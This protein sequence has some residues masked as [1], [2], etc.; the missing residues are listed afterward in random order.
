[1]A[2]RTLTPMN[3]P[4]TH[5]GV[6]LP[7]RAE[8]HD[9]P[10]RLATLLAAASLATLLTQLTVFASGTPVAAATAPRTP[11][12]A[13]ES[14]A[15]T[16]S[17]GETVATA[18]A[19]SRV[20]SVAAPTCSRAYE[21]GGPSRLLG[22]V[23]EVSAVVDGRVRARGW[24]VDLD[25]PAAP[26]T[27]RTWTGSGFDNMAPAAVN[28]PDV[29]TAVPGAG[30]GHGFDVTLMVGEGRARFALQAFRS[31]PARSRV[32]TWCTADVPPMG[33][34][35]DLNAVTSPV[36]GALRVIGWA[37]DPGAP[38]QPVDIRV[39]VNGQPRVLGPATGSRPDVSEA[40]PGVGAAHGFDR[41][42]GGLAGGSVQVCAYALSRRP[43]SRDTLVGCRWV[44]VP[45]Q[46][47][48][49]PI[50]GLDL[51]GVAGTN[52]IRAAGWAIN[53]ERSTEPVNVRLSVGGGPGI[54]RDVE[55]GPAVVIRPDVAISRPGAG[56]N[57]GFDSAVG[58][59]PAGRVEVCAEAADPEGGPS[60]LLGCDVVDVPDNLGYDPIGDVNGLGSPGP[61]QIR[62]VG[63]ALQRSS[64][65]LSLAVHIYVDGPAGV[66]SGLA[67]APAAV[68]RPDVAVVYADAGPEHGFDTTLS[69]YPAGWHVVCVYA[70][71][72]GSLAGRNPLLDCQRV[73]VG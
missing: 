34:L 46:A 52:G 54:G 62:A 68:A 32:L 69:G 17:A 12:A 14:M 61:G 25:A 55:V 6:A 18:A 21:V 26:V 5:H 13:T 56:P 2:N 67:L 66:G 73:L 47:P 28:R 27:V 10:R 39:D 19:S 57:H 65:R 41:I 72:Q 31:S 23:D 22:Y 42:I 38:G 3:R 16:V 8:R 4:E 60:S 37:L 44:S 29:A 71:G 20:P 49:S 59:I 64:P 35:G 50:G 7:V 48:G 58:R 70:L 40:Y 24:V 43:T 11:T 36:A 51:L 63:W 1:M 53:P 15:S 30:P 33:P 9:E 45:A